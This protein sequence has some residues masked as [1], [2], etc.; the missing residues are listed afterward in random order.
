MRTPA[1]QSPLGSFCRTCNRIDVGLG[2]EPAHLAHRATTSREREQSDGAVSVGSKNR[3][4]CE[5]R[6]PQPSLPLNWEVRITHFSL[7][8]AVKSFSLDLAQPLIMVA[9]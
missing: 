2:I 1:Q 3:G 5:V 4:N 8:S 7:H 9:F 6:C